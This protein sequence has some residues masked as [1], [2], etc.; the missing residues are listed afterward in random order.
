MLNTSSPYATVELVWLRVVFHDVLNPT[1]PR[2]AHASTRGPRA[3]RLSPGV[4]LGLASAALLAFLLVPLAA[5]FIRAVPSGAVGD[6]LDDPLVRA[7]LTL[8]LISTSVSLLLAVVLGLPV[9]YLLARGRFPG[10]R[11]LD[12]LIDLPMVLPPAV[13][14]VGLLMAFG[15]RGLFGPFL[16]QSFGIELP[17]T[18]A[19]VVLAQTFVAAPF[20]VKAAKA[21]FES[22]DR[23]LER[24]ASLD[25]TRWRVFCSITLPLTYPALL[26]GAVMTWARALGEFGA[27]IMFA[28]NFQGRTQ[29]MPLAIYQTLEAGHLNSALVLSGLLVIVSFAVLVAF[30]SL[31]HLASGS[32]DDMHG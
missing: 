6:A 10:R 14:G 23:D 29:T 8:S 7:A 3:R 32:D 25:A 13:A 28:G 9:A 16:S 30:K 5:I 12:S 26:G 11:L 4:F 2:P 17:F 18:T 1:A 31:A 24:A 21:G 20:F 27:T 22:I 19:A 15:R